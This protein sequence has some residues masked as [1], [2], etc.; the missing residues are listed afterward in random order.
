MV[1]PHP[2]VDRWVLKHFETHAMGHGDF[3]GSFLRNPQMDPNGQ[4]RIVFQSSDVKSRQWQTN[5]K[6]FN[7]LRGGIHWC[8]SAIAPDLWQLTPRNSWAK[9]RWSWN[10][11]KPAVRH[12]ILEHHGQ[13]GQSS[14]FHHP[15]QRPWLI[16]RRFH[17]RR[18]PER[19]P[20]LLETLLRHSCFKSAQIPS[21]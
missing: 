13:R 19:V 9:F 2:K 14:S 18:S 11:L 21:N 15:H 20:I 10:H 16:L 8:C 4:G 17:V 1:Y 6:S 5:T 3:F 12:K 7:A